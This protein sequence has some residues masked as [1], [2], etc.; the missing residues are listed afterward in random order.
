[1]KITEKT[2]AKEIANAAL[3]MDSDDLERAIV[4]FAK[5]RHKE[6]RHKACDILTEEID[7]QQPIEAS[8]NGEIIV[9]EETRILRQKNEPSL[10]SRIINIPFRQPH[11]S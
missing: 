1:V 10:I 9:V 5:Y 3:D 2:T 6:A 4:L 7:C 8:M 11:S